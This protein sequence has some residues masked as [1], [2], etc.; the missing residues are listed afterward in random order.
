[1]WLKGLNTI[2]IRPSVLF[3][4]LGFGCHFL[5]SVVACIKLGRPFIPIHDKVNLN[6]INADDSILI[7][8]SFI[9]SLDLSQS[10]ESFPYE[11]VADSAPLYGIMTSG[12][13]GDPKF[14]YFTYYNFK[15]NR[16]C[17]SE[18]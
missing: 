8:E 13:T 9:N 1:M 15:F 4:N 14:L 16:I 17:R 10:C 6:N 3:I 7:D 2:T 11:Q 12:T 18:Y 5:S